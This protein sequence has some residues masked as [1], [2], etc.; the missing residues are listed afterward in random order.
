MIADVFGSKI[1]IELTSWTELRLEE[2]ISFS[3]AG[4]SG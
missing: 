1:E 3:L 4:Y 2:M